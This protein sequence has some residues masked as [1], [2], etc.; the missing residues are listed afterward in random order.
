M[1][2]FAPRKIDSRRPNMRHVNA[3]SYLAL[4]GAFFGGVSLACQ[5]GSFVNT[6]HC[7]N[8]DGDQTC[9]ERFGDERPFCASPEGGCGGGTNYGCVAEL[10]ADEC[11]SACGHGTVITDDP[12]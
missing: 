10:P 2:I 6:G 12:S 11:Y 8:A 3:I 9:A 4:V 5:S 7:F 1:T